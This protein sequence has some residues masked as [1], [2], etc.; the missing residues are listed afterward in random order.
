MN[1]NGSEFMRDHAEDRVV[2]VT[3]ASSGIGRATALAFAMSGSAVV[4]AARRADALET[5][6][7]LCRAEGV[8]ALAVPTDVSDAEQ[9]EALGRE[10][11]RAFGRIDVWVNNAGVAQFGRFDETPLADF[12]RVLDV[13]L[14]GAVHGARVALRQFREQGHGVI[15]NV[16]SVVGI[17]PQAF[18][19]AYAASKHALRGF[20][21]SLRMELTFDQAPHIH[22]CSVL[23]ASYDTPIFA[24]AAN[25]TGW[26]PRPLTPTNDP[27]DLA[28]A[29]LRIARRPR[30]EVVVGKGGRL[31][32]LAHAVAPALY[33]P[34][35]A[36][37]LARGHFVH[38]AVARG[39]GN[40][41]EPARHPASVRGGWRKPR[42]PR[43]WSFAG[44][45][46]GLSA[47][48]LAGLVWAGARRTGSMPRT[49]KTASS[50]ASHD[51][52]YQP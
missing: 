37:V 28:A 46:L 20:A 16:G 25:Y 34:I 13:N 26:T 51:R 27:V 45:L 23:P 38:R 19:S 39:P 11:L 24:T 49:A 31:A 29:I 44:E 32:V 50:G 5:V 40:L 7:D 3:G 17:V 4:L 43:T 36:G 41:Y 47:C 14:L 22:V 35:M 52:R 30:R 10:A 15:V 21:D 1:G 48:L 2:V 9:V 12:R 42:E 33:E 18:T 6:A 8:R